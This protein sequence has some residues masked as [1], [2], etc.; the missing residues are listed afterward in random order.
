MC[1]H[2]IMRH[3]A[4]PATFQSAFTLIEISIVLVIIGLIVGG[5]L[6][7]QNLINAASIRAQI[8]Q[9]EKY[10]TAVRT[11]QG[12][13]GY[14]PG[15]IPDPFATSFGF[16]QRGT[17]AGE[18]DGNGLLEGNCANTNGGNT[19]IRNGCGELAV[20][21]EDLSKPGLI[22]TVIYGHDTNGTSYPYTSGPN[23]LPGTNV[24][25]TTTPSIYQWLPLAKLGQNNF[26]YTYSM[27]G[28]NY[29]AI[30]SV[31]I[32][33]WDIESSVNPGIT[34]Q[35]ASMIDSKMDDG[36]PQSGSVFAGYVNKIVSAGNCIYAAGNNLQ[37]ANGGFNSTLMLCNPTTTATSYLSTNC[38]DNTGT[39]GVQKYSLQQNA[40]IAN[41]ALSFRFQ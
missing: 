16:Q 40:N 32:I 18:G 31:T 38:Y 6:T 10:N 9:I 3:P 41:C 5:I 29:F 35:Q 26:I 12:K 36:L 13:Y 11:F 37:G 30:S 39:A 14:L 27:A 8:A 21:W 17:Y 1:I 20:F 34:V 19:G 25:F 15:D 24:L 28:M 7:G 23:G 4:T 2:N 22:D 33:E